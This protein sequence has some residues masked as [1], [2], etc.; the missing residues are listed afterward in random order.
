MTTVAAFGRVRVRMD[1]L[2]RTEARKC[3]RWTITA[4]FGA[5][6]MASPSDR[7]P[8]NSTTPE[9]Q[10][11]RFS[12]SRAKCNDS[13]SLCTKIGPFHGVIDQILLDDEPRRSSSDILRHR[14][15][16]AFAT[17]TT[18]SA[19]MPKCSA[20]AQ[21]PPAG[22]GNIHST[23]ASSRP[24]PRSRFRPHPRRFPRRP[25]ACFIPGDDLGVFELSL[26]DGTAL[27]ANR[28]NS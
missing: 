10:S 1:S 3:L 14:C 2:A 15:S 9:T 13:E 21:A 25:P 27:R 6:A 16:V 20:I 26:R 12:P 17:N 5:V 23:G 24:T 19:D 28:G 8:G 18:T 22:T 11:G 4:L 7:S